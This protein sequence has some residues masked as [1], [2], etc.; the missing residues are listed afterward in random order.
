MGQLGGAKVTKVASAGG[1]IM[2]GMAKFSKV[3]VRDRLGR[4][5]S[6]AD[7][8][9]TGPQRAGEKGKVLQSTVCRSCS[10]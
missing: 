6:T 4:S 8:E 10:M 2:E 1:Q 7:R 5:C 9:S 3:N